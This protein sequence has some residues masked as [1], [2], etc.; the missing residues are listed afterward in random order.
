[1]L[2]KTYFPLYKANSEKRYKDMEKKN[3]QLRKAYVKYLTFL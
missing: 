2:N 3:R 1:M